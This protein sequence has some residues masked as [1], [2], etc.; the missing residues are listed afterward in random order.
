MIGNVTYDETWVISSIKKLDE[1]VWLG[2]N[3]WKSG[4]LSVKKSGIINETK[5]Y[6]DT[7]VIQG[8]PLGFDTKYLAL[9]DRNMQVRFSLK[10]FWEFW[11]VGIWCLTLCFGWK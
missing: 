9:G 3:F 10:V 4:I 11:V 8:Q 2:S 7:T 1:C 6:S 5:N